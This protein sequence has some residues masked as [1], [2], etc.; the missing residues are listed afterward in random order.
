MNSESFKFQ[1][2]LVLIIVLIFANLIF[3]G[4]SFAA[5]EIQGIDGIF[6]Y[7]ESLFQNQQYTAA[8]SE[9]LQLLSIDSQY[10]YADIARYRLGWCA[11]YSGKNELAIAQFTLLIQSYP[12]STLLNSAK[13]ARQ[14]LYETAEI[15]PTVDSDPAIIPFNLA[16]K[17]QLD[18]NEFDALSFYERVVQ[19]YS[20]SVYAIYAAYNIAQIQ[21][22]NYERLTRS[23]LDKTS[24]YRR[25][26]WE[27]NNP[28]VPVQL[29]AE[30]ALQEELMQQ[31]K[32]QMIFA[33]A[34]VTERYPDSFQSQLA[35]RDLANF[36]LKTG[37][38]EL[39]KQEYISLLE[40]T[41]EFPN[42]IFA[43]QAQERLHQL[44]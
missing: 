29:Y 38:P 9:Y 7:A 14:Y 25:E 1:W 4:D 3:I 13:Q 34:R 20:N 6:Q 21:A 22:A 15:I 17:L 30:A 27:K 39:A 8:E 16:R 2:Y 35:H 12:K 24:D 36:Y 37:K 23:Y 11:Y 5:E 31:Q 44:K 18:K 10:R 32:Q 43:Y 42:S 40:L 41:R 28:R 33:F 19:N 26:V